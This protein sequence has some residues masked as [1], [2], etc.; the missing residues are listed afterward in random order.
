MPGGEAV[1]GLGGAVAPRGPPAELPALGAP[2]RAESGAKPRALQ[3]FQRHKWDDVGN[4]RPV[5]LTSIPDNIMGELIQ[6][7]INKKLKEVI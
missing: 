5:R 1:A 2:S 7:L 3:L 4:Y 6:D